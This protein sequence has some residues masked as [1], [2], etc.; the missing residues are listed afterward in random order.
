VT[1]AST[2]ALEVAGNRDVMVWLLLDRQ[3]PNLAGLL[4]NPSPLVEGISVLSCV[5]RLTFRMNPVHVPEHRGSDML[6]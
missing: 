6:P 3:P 4:V 2:L 5:H 1:L